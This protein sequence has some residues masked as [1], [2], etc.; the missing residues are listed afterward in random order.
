MTMKHKVKATVLDT[1]FYPEYQRQYCANPCSGKCPVY[2]KGDEFVFFR[3]DERADYWHCGL[4][5]SRRHARTALSALSNV[6]FSAHTAGNYS[7]A[8]TASQPPSSPGKPY[9]DSHNTLLPNIFQVQSCLLIFLAVIHD[10]L[11]VG[12]R[13]LRKLLNQW[14][15]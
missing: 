11:H 5:S 3:D 6:L 7:V 14:E 9:R 12:L 10:A 2:N 4:N 1:K 13:P 8:S 15:K